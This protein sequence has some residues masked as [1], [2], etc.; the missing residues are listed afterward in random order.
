MA[1][2][3][4]TMPDHADKMRHKGASATLRPRR[5]SDAPWPRFSL[6]WL[7]AVAFG[8]LVALAV[9]SVL[10]LSVRANFVNTLSLLNARAVDLIEGMERQIAAEASQAERVVTALSGLYSDGSID[11]V[12]G[13]EQ[14]AVLAALLRTAPAVEGIFLFDNDGTAISMF[15]IPGDE[16]GPQ[17]E[18]A[19]LRH[20]F[21]LDTAR[22]A[23]KP[24]WGAPAALDG[25]LF[26][27][28]ALPL[29]RDGTVAGVAVAVV[30]QDM[31]S[32]IMT[33]LA[34]E[35]DATVFMLS[36][37]DHVVS[38]S[39]LPEQFEGREIKPIGAFPDEV[40]RQLPEATEARDYGE[41]A[42]HG[43]RVFNTQ[44]GRTG[45]IF[46]TK[47]L[48]GYSARPFTLGVYFRK[49]DLGAEMLRAINSL[50]V[51]LVGLISAV[52]A[53]ILLGRR[54]S[55]PMAHVA[56]AAAQFSD[57]RLDDIVP[58]SRSRIREIDDQAVALNRMRTIVLQF[59]RYV[60]RE[61]VARLV[62]TGEE[63][64]HPVERDVT[65]LFSDI[66]GFT[67]ISERMNAAEVA[68]VLNQHFEIMTRSVEATGGT[69]DKF[70]GD[71]VMAFWGAPE[72]DTDHVLHAIRATEGIVASI[73]AENAERRLRGEDP[74]RV[75][76]GIHTGRVVVGNI[77]GP[78][79]QNYTI[80]G[81]TVNVAQRLEQL[82][83]ELLGPEDDAVALV[84]CDVV[85]AANGQADF[86][87]AG[88]R[89]IRGRER[90]VEVAILNVPETFALAAS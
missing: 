78:D 61:L 27:N 48:S 15:R 32:Q 17:A 20:V 49:A 65:I 77:G 81:D 60:P 57:F 14:R 54:I 37:D 75:R 50:A 47:Q 44:D 85:E 38:H 41:A 58:L 22:K 36:E 33:R 28:V 87:P 86:T 53:A 89:D 74:L 7:L 88:S 72:V 67:S 29:R 2:A 30:G 52:F 18:A 12:D 4:A 5:R 16:F 23:G 71:G 56:E 1:Q 51:G 83:R 82:S 25:G 45:H 40:L 64:G 31:V 90:P 35:S 70:M 10:A 62:R 6:S 63:A 42:S 11:L 34:R 79:R 24:S 76:M 55:R 3:E 73:R 68:H 8:G 69:I 84:S 66:T 46:L 19:R 9:G 26:H 59:T 21:D 13:P 43:I 39:R 80:V